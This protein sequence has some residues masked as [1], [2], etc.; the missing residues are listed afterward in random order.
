MRI[1]AGADLALVDVIGTI[2]GA[3]MLRKLTVY[4]VVLLALTLSCACDAEA[5]T[6]TKTKKTKARPRVS[7]VLPAPVSSGDTYAAIVIEANSGRILHE[8][9]GSS[10]RHPASLT[11]MM[12][13]YL[14]FQAIENGVIRLETPLP[15]SAKAAGQSPTKLGL[16]AGQTVRAYDAIMGLVT[17][18]A[19]DAA[20]VIAE[21]LGGST[22][23]F[24]EMMIAQ[25][26]ALGMRRTVFQ[27]PNGL[28]D[29]EQVTCARDMAI[30]GYALVYHYPGFYPYFSH[31]SFVY[32]GRSYNN[33]NNLMKRYDGMD[34]IKTGY[35]RAS[36][37]NL[38]SSAV[39][40][41][42]RL[43]GAIFGGRSA[44]SR[45]D[46]MANMLDDGFDQVD[47]PAQTRDDFL[48]LPSKVAAVFGGRRGPQPVRTS[49]QTALTPP[50]FE[51]GTEED[52]QARSVG[53][54]I[55]VGAYS[56][57]AGAQQSLAVM[58]RQMAPLLGGAEQSIQKITMSDGS[59]M[60]RA[61][62]MGLDQKMAR[63]ACSYMVRHGQS[64]LV[65]SG[66]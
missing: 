10:I 17:E 30:L 24:A 35:I 31:N 66:P 6:R 60:Y 34:G 55:Q 16:R 21:A 38:V 41:E 65:V 29:P 62:F 61:R 46:Q 3:N 52:Q 15:V 37:F 14:A 23:R 18:S 19:N 33:H 64:C 26:R 8:V 44:A 13:L 39:R 2:F 28:P 45:D 27:N 54:G 47:R 12:T 4:L 57:V 48:P 56:D 5:K 36:G 58:A 53:W 11:K 49:A 32:K 59:P 25:A 50:V 7:R 1:G 20:V 40:G 42:T 63:D 22:E 9:N 43:I 51:E